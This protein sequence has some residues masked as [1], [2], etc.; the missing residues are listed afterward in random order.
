M[1]ITKVYIKEYK[2]LRDFHWELHENSP[3]SVIIGKNAS[4]KT[5]LLVALIKI[6]INALQY[7]QGKEVKSSFDFSLS[8]Q[9]D[10]GDLFTLQSEKDNFSFFQNNDPKQA[11]RERNNLPEKIFTYYAGEAKVFPKLLIDNKAFD[12]FAYLFPQDTHFLLLA[13]FGSRLESIKNDIL[14]KQFGITQ[15]NSFEITIQNPYSKKIDKPSISNFFGAPPDL[16]AFFQKLKSIS[17]YSKGNVVFR[18]AQLTMTIKREGFELLMENM[19]EYDL[20]QTLQRCSNLGYI[21]KIDNFQFIKEGVEQPIGFDDLS[22]GERQRIGLLGAFAVYQ[23]KETL[24]LLDEPD[25]FAHP[26]WQWDFVPD[27]QNAIGHTA[28]QQVIFATH[29][30][31][32]LSTV[33]ENAFM[34]QYGKIEELNSV[35]GQDANASLI[36]MGV[37]DR[38]DTI[39]EKLST[40]YAL[41]ES[42]KAKETATQQLK[43]ELID[44]LGLNHPALLQAIALETFY[45]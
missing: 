38:Y 24:F 16:V 44:E 33:K 23:G 25:A 19:Y 4:G 42:G 31:L 28:S 35:F 27:L 29:S 37:T 1:R 13:M 43:Q 21:R 3:I 14:Y 8:Y 6:F 9:K 36:K 11:T 22:E 20:Y 34:L 32:V 12:L 18:N 39:K 45:E 17:E 26:R 5:N 15:L 30:P 40:Y 2:N 41:L 10:N 7:T